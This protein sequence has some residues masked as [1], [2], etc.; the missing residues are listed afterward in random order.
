MASL[1]FIGEDRLLFTFR[2]PGLIHR[3]FKDGKSEES[4]ERQIKAVVLKLPS[5]TVEAESLWTVHDRE[6]YLWMMNDGQ[7]LVRD[8]ASLLKG[9]AQLSLKPFL[10]FPGPVLRLEVDPSLQFVV[11]NSLEPVAK[12]ESGPES[13]PAKPGSPAN[14]TV[15]TDQPNSDDAQENYVVR[16]LRLDTGQVMLVSRAR[17]V[18]HL[19]INSEAFVENLRGRA[20]EWVL[21]LNYFSGG[22]HILGSVNSACVPSSEFLTKQELL[23]TGCDNSGALKLVAMTMDGATLW[24]DLNP[25][26][27]IWPILS[28]SSGGKRV[29]QEMLVVTHPVNAYA[30][31]GSDEIKG[32]LVRVLDAASGEIVFESPVSPVLDAGGNVAISPSGRRVALTNGGAIQIFEL[33]EAA[34]PVGPGTKPRYK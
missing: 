3:Q 22:T 16:I 23:V 15:T 12:L 18:V 17:G 30:P 1:D 29:A 6:R 8:K 7:F 28:S 2:V 24:D 25:A 10:Q 13:E 11:S 20:D 27:D 21:N 4:D 32:Q 31:L 14:D 34:A 5:G 26:T 19:P 9:D 33:P